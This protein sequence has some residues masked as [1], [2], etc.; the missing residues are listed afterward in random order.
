MNHGGRPFDGEGTGPLYDNKSSQVLSP[1]S[2]PKSTQDG[3]WFWLLK[4][5]V[6][7]PAETFVGPLYA[8]SFPSNVNS[9]ER[10][11]LP[12][13]AS[14]H[15]DRGKGR[16]KFLPVFGQKANTVIFHMAL[17]KSPN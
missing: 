12:Q 9:K 10:V 17:E 4:T 6:I 11:S 14:T 3:T 1:S 15:I 13:P 2:F 7:S 8:Q 5:N 16:R